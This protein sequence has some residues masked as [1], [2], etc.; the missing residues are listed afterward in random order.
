MSWSSLL[1]DNSSMAKAVD[2][3]GDRWSLMV[4]SGC[5]SGVCRFNQFESFLGI[6]RNLLSARLDKLVDAG[7][8]VRHLYN[9][10]PPRYEYQLTNIA[11]DL[12]PIIVGLS[13]WAECHFTKTDA[14]LTVVHKK[15]EQKVEVIIRCKSC[16]IQVSNDDVATKLNPCAGPEA[17]RLFESMSPTS[18]IID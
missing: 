2:L 15:C 1:K 13:A 3:V 11:Q 16:E 14:P 18:K 6:N 10:S 17:L 12:R 9:A 4:L 8:L 5:F 7:L